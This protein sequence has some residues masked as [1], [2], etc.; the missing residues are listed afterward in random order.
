MSLKETEVVKELSGIE[1]ECTHY[2]SVFLNHTEG[3]N[4][5]DA[6]IIDRSRLITLHLKDIPANKKI[7][8]RLQD[9]GYKLSMFD[10]DIV[11]TVQT[12]GGLNIEENLRQ[13]LLALFI[14]YLELLKQLGISAIKIGEKSVKLEEIFSDEL[15]LNELKGRRAIVVKV[16]KEVNQCLLEP[17]FIEGDG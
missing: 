1:A 6:P 10:D 13:T 2:K 15:T 11:I 14:G 3:I 4:D 17:L 7:L 8:Q 9:C 16:S 12:T 5:L